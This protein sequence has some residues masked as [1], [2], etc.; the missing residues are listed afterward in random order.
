MPIFFN[1]DLGAIVSMVMI[2]AMILNTYMNFACIRII[3]ENPEQWE[4]SSMKTNT[5]FMKFLCILASLCAAFVGFQLFRNLKANEMIVMLVI[6][7]VISSLS[8][9]NI[10]TGRVSKEQLDLRKK[11]ILEEAYANEEY[12]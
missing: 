6:L 11:K 7:L 5:G 9:F 10:K 4:K 2:P 12:L 8:I 3:D 1:V